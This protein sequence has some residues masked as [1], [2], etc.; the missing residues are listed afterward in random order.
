[1]NLP[2]DRLR[3]LFLYT[4]ESGV[5]QW[6]ERPLSDFR[7]AADQ[8]TW[9]TKNAGQEAGSLHDS[10]G[11]IYRRVVIDGKRYYAHRIACAMHYGEWPEM[12]DHIN[13]DGLDNRAA[14][15][16]LSS[17]TDNPKNQALHKDNK[18]GLSGVRWNAAREQYYARIGHTR[19]GEYGTLLDAA[20]ARI[21]AEKRMGY[22]G[23]IGR[24]SL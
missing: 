10:G 13:G 21:S 7:R 5:I 22:I 23:A 19:L 20:A 15:I 8:A 4:P 24:V 11:R 3:S 12:V 9:N 18:S 17:A 2:I 16:R 6:R 14:N 1:M